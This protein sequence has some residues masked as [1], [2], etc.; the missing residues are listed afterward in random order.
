MLHAFPYC[1]VKKLK[2]T[3]QKLNARQPL[4]Q[5]EISNTFG[6]EVHLLRLAFDDQTHVA[7]KIK[8]G[9]RPT[10]LWLSELIWSNMSR[11]VLTSIQTFNQLTTWLYWWKYT[12]SLSSDAPGSKIQRSFPPC[13]TAQSELN[14]STYLLRLNLTE[15]RELR[16][17]QPIVKFTHM[18]KSRQNDQFTF[19]FK[20][21]LPEQNSSVN[22]NST[23]V[24]TL[25]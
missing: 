15:L 23:E 18:M 21:T 11:L 6:I 2:N 1:L 22:A 16:P 25:I 14:I 19:R 17:S 13:S 10:P 3:L 20:K 5:E 4:M 12:W 8:P 7:L 9:N 24:E